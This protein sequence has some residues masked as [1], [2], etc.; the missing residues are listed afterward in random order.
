MLLLASLVANAHGAAPA[1]ATNVTV[2]QLDRRL[3]GLRDAND[4]SVARELAGLKL[5]ERVSA[6][7]LTRWQTGLH[8]ERGR[9]A[10][11]AL[12]DAAAFLPLPAAEVLPKAAPDGAIQDQILA[13]MTDYVKGTLPKLPN[14]VA[15]RTTTAFEV[16][17][18]DYLQTQQ[19]MGTLLETRRGRQSTR[20]ALGPAGANGLP[21]AQLFYAGSI[22]QVI[23]Y[24]G[25]AEELEAA[26]GSTD[27]R[28]APFFSLTTTGEFGPVLE[29]ILNDVA[30][31]K[32]VWDHWERGET[33]AVAVFDYSVPHD[34]SHFG[35]AF[36]SDQVPE[37]PAY[38]G[39]IAVDPAKGTVLRITQLTHVREE[40]ASHDAATLVEFG[41]AQIGGLT[42]TVPVHGVAK[43]NSLDPFANEDDQPPPVPYQTSINDITFTNYHVFRTKS[44]VM[45][46][47]LG[48]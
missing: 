36:T 18:A 42:Y 44:R 4:K 40:D 8:S 48:P 35:V 47:G 1:T 29:L 46:G 28:S 15:L 43:A 33:G 30:R 19:N 10:L 34:R 23:A 6:Q 39:E 14:F 41:S 13:R 32:I 16:T 37:L 38:H 12:A 11:L 9:E 21:N 27:Q 7:R 5:T 25:G 26:P 17:T 24:R 45:T 22:A 3:A 31:D 2:E 20:V